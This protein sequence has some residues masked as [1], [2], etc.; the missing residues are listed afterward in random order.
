MAL[1]IDAAAHVGALDAGGSTI[2]VLGCGVDVCY[3][4]RHAELRSRIIA[5]GSLITEEPRWD[6][7]VQAQLPE[8]QSHHRGPRPTPS[9][10]SRPPNAAEP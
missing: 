4:A 8:A 3:P 5:G 6:A 2:A 7:A 1:G 10:W 9:S